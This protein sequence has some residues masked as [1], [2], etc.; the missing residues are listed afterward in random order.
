MASLRN[1]PDA[2][3][4]FFTIVLLSYSSVT[5]NGADHVIDTGKTGEPQI[6]YTLFWTGFGNQVSVVINVVNPI[7]IDALKTTESRFPNPAPAC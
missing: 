7:R 4:S 1:E 2:T 3:S 5:G 6:S